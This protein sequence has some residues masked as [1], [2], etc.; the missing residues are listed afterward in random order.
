MEENFSFGYWLRRQ[1][2]ARDLRQADLAGQLG[3]AA[4]TLRKIE[5][6]ERRPSLQLIDRLAAVFGLSADERASL[7]RV[8]RS[9]LRPAALPLP[10]AP[11]AAEPPAQGAHRHNLPAQTTSLIGRERELADLCALL[12]QP[13]RR[14]VTLTGPGGTGKTRLA[15]RAATELLDQFPQGVWFVNLAPLTRPGLL[16]P[17][18]AQTLAVRAI[19]ARSLVDT[20]CDALRDQRLLLLLDNFEQIISAA[21]ALAPLLAA[22][23]GLQLLVTSRESL[24]LSGEQIVVVPPLAM[25]SLRSLAVGQADLA[26][27]LSRYEAVRLFVERARAMRADFALTDANAPAVAAICA[28]LDGLPLAIE[29]AAARA[30]LFT[31]EAL[32]QRLSDRLQLLTGGPRDLPARQQTLRGAIAWSYTLLPPDEQALF[33]RC[34]VFVG[35]W[36]AAAAAAVSRRDAAEVLDVL[37]AL[38]DKSLVYET[39]GA[40]GEPRFNMLET[41]R[42]YALERLEQAGEMP[43]A[44]ADHAAFYL[45]LAE[46]IEP[47]LRAARASAWMDL[48]E[49]DHENLR[50][51]LSWLGHL[52]DHGQVVR[53]CYALWRYWYDRGHWEEGR[54]ALEIAI[55]PDLLARIPADLQ[56]R[57]Q[58]FAGMF[59]SRQSEFARGRALFERASALFCAQADLAGQIDCLYGLAIVSHG[60]SDYATATSMLREAVRLG[61]DLGDRYRTAL[62]LDWLNYGLYVQGEV[63]EAEAVAHEALAIFRELEATEHVGAMLANLGYSAYGRGDLERAAA[64][65]EE[66]IAL[67]RSF[68]SSFDL[69]SALNYF[70]QILSALGQPARAV[71]LCGEA[72]ELRQRLGDRRGTIA[73]LVSIATPTFD[74]EGHRRAYGYLRAALALTNELSYAQGYAWVLNTAAQIAVRAGEIERAARLL[75][76]EEAYIQAQQIP[77]WPEERHFVAQVWARAIAAIG[78]AAAVA[79]WQAGRVLELEQALALALPLDSGGQYD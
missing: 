24:H 29:L 70:G 66:S 42:A 37:S 43:D 23:P 75:G 7:L 2:L 15:L 10:R 48:L 51:A 57:A 64:L 6:D 54:Q 50:S 19:G 40:D 28:R 38:A 39:S 35:A 62:C 14:I 79:A 22:A 56:A 9:D 49:A 77:L 55:R 13:D 61:R 41:I 65:L 26:L 27:S 31:P 8:A 30:R 73:V 32:L 18:I 25:P 11:A 34:G 68:G 47:H 60:L 71:A 46:A 69:S 1:R 36:S 45:Q 63:A 20:L 58:L 44:Q 17:A 67:L 3:V 12:R 21:V 78:E 74:L 16:I 72:L 5:A 4:I 53:L 52:G 33:R 59:L 76:A